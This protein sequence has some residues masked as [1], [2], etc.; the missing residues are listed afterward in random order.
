MKNLRLLL[1]SMFSLFVML[2]LS[3]QD[4]ANDYFV[5]KWEVLVEGTP[6]GDSKM[7]VVIERV[8]GKLAG[9]V[10]RDGAQPAKTTR[11]DEKKDK[12]VTVYFNSSGYDVYLY[13]EK[14]GDNAV[15]GSLMDMFDA[16][17]KRVK[18]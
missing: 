13:M 10:S 5:G 11:V 6:S 8:D 12:S 14:K 4:Q 7:E 15:E 3:A 16:T 2:T 18:E 1:A 17:G 9:T